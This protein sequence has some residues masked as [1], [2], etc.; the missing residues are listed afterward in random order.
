MQTTGLRYRLAEDTIDETDIQDLIGWLQGNP[1]LT[2]G[3]L[4]RE[5]EQRWAEW[6]G[7]RH[8]VYVNS[9]SSANLLMYYAPLVSG[10]LK[11]RKIVVPAVSWSTS[12]APAVQL[13]FEPLMCEADPLTLGLDPDHL[14]RLVEEH[15]PAAVLLV[16][17]LGVPCQ[18]GPI[19]DLQAKHGFVL[20][21]DSCA[22]MG[23]RFDGKL[24]G[25]LGDLST[26]S[27]YFGHHS[28]TIEGGMVCTDDPHLH[29][30]LLHLRSHGWAK[31]LP[32]ERQDELARE[33]GVAPFNKL[34]TFY[35]PGF[36]VRATD[37]QARIGLSQ[38]R[39]LDRVLGRRTENDALYRQR[40]AGSDSFACQA[41]PRAQI[42]SI[43]FM[44]MAASREHRARVLEVMAHAGIE[45]RPVGGGNMSRQPFWKAVYGEQPFP[46]AERL[47]EC[48]I[49]MPNHHGLT[50]DDVNHIC[51]VVLSVPA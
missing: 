2:M 40:F 38:M 41:N 46:V 34:F 8:A 19:L 17:V 25:S 39:K 51:D 42:C 28:S 29:E 6:L 26:F 7:V 12:V 27:L 49:Q 9:G 24:V 47:E 4:V 44:T 36:N 3:P 45:T 30:I 10:R 18:M 20:M 32:P 48:G 37:L 14:R 23:S 5:F 21:E 13:G 33:H 15:D 1:W 16:H 11:N 35:Y 31:D 43:A 50:A 22:A